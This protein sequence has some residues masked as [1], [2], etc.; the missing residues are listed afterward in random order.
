MARRLANLPGARHHRYLV[1]SEGRILDHDADTEPDTGADASDAGLTSPRY[2]PPARIA[3]HVTVRDQHCVHPGCRRKARRCELDHRVPWP[4]GPTSA[5]NLEPLCRRHH[6]LKHHSQW[7]AQRHDDGTYQ[8]TSP[9][10]HT[11]HYRPPELPVPELPAPEPERAQD[12][13]PPPF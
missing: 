9:T 2:T 4:N 1:D 10:R 3:R 5:E 8:W 13:E 11:Y 6:N 12:V 7:R